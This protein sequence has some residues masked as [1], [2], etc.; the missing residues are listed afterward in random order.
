MIRLSANVITS[1]IVLL[2]QLDNHRVISL[3]ELAYC[4]IDSIAIEDISDFCQRCCWVEVEAEKLILTPRGEHILQ[5][6]KNEEAYR[7]DMLE[8]YVLKCSPIWSS[9]IPYGRKEASLFM[10]DD[11]R[12]CFFEAELLNKNI[13]MIALKWWDTLSTI[14]RGRSDQENAKIGREGERRTV[15]YEKNRTGVSPKWI[16]IESNLVGYDI[17]SQIDKN[18]AAPLLIEVK[19]SKNVL[20]DACFYITSHEW[21]VACTSKSYIIH[22][23]LLSSVGNQL[24]ILTPD[25]VRSYI[26]TNNLE[27]QWED[28]KIPYSCFGGKFVTIS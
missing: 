28:A 9:R 27:G 18:D 13:D 16:S 2:Q 4:K 5:L 25:E 7:L 24:A 10:S 22:L 3:G 6:Y 19:A 23:W 12:A 21:H 11:E 8:D 14:I 20:H 17:Q 1:A 26:P 15:Q